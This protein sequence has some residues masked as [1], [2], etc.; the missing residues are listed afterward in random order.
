MPPL[1]DARRVVKDFGATR[2]LA[3]LDLRVRAG[4][5]HALVG[6]N[7]AGKSTFIKIL[8]G[9]HE[10]DGGAIEIAGEPLR[11]RRDRIA[12]IHQ[13]LGLVEAMSVADNFGLVAGFGSGR[14]LV[15]DRRL[16]RETAASL[17]AL[18]VTLDPRT[19]V[20]EL[21]VS[22]RTLVAVARA[23]H[24]D[25]R[26]VVLDEPTASLPAADV[27]RLFGALR[28]LRDRGVGVLY[29]SHRLP[30][31]RALADRITVLRGGVAELTVRP[32]EATEAQLAAS[33]I[34]AAV[35]R[36]PR[37]AP[38][39][40]GDGVALRVQGLVA[41]GVGPLDVQVRAGEVIGC[42]GLRG[43]GQEALGRALYGLLGW[44]G[45]V[46]VGGVDYRAAAPADALR[47]GVAYVGGDRGLS[48]A[49]GLTV[50]ENLLINPVRRWV[51]PRRERALARALI[52]RY[53]IV[54][55]GSASLVGTLSGGNAQKIALAR[56]LEAAP[57]VLLLE[58]PTAGVDVGARA[59][60]YRLVD[61]ARARGL[62][63]VLAS[64][65]EEEICEMS[66]RVLVFGRGGV[67][68]HLA[69]GE[70]TADRV[71][72]AVMGVVPT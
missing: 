17:A 41:G 71:G 6:R 36:G 27:E 10:P 62:A 72:S 33:I 59:E 14:G 9:L 25:A 21:P 45:A 34:G 28:R 30:E 49:R 11:R 61:D 13:D 43:A 47:A 54:A 12:F 18:G 29:V 65:D 15:A 44:T 23:L 57:R 70:V 1:I 5:I 68:A 52:E 35:A 38:K 48:L 39:L 22:D 16:H 46:Q 24:L 66:D 3:G 42:A 56:A 60:F 20:S 53:G 31:V 51:S 19:L 2:A 63:V 58:E 8:A 37:A 7:G 40:A 32:E 55:G 64:S 69:E 50:A 26:A 67:R 4:E